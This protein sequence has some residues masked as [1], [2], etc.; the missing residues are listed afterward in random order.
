MAQN[1]CFTNRICS[2]ARNVYF[3]A[4]HGIVNVLH[5]LAQNASEFKFSSVASQL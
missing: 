3:E 1:S 2:F 5:V 4:R